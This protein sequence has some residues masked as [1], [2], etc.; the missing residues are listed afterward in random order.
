MAEPEQFSIFHTVKRYCRNC[1]HPLPYKAK[2]CANCGQKDSDGRIGMKSLMGRLWNNTFH[3]EGKFV[4]TAWQ[5]FIPGKVTLEF[6]KGKQDRYPHPIRLFAIVMFLFLFLLNQLWKN[7]DA[8][9]ESTYFSFQ[10][11]ED[12][13]RNKSAKVIDSLVTEVFDSTDVIDKANTIDSTVEEPSFSAYEKMKYNAVLY[14]IKYD[15]DSLPPGLKTPQA[16]RAVDSLMKS[17]AKRYALKNNGLQDSLLQEPLDSIG[18]GMGLWGGG[19]QVATLD[20]VRYDP[21]EIIKRYHVTSWFEKTM[22]RQGIK[23]YKT[24]E[25]FIHA[26]IG[27]LTWAILALV[28]LMS[29]VLALLYT[30]QHRYYVEHFIFLL[31]FHTGAMLLLLLALLGEM[32]GIWGTGIIGL[33]AMLPFPGMYL[34]MRR[35]YNQG[36]FKTFVKWLLYGFLYVF[37]FTF[38]FI[39]GMII[40]FAVF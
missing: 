8:G 32:L 19:V 17:F 34:G 14:D 15:Y 30:R 39:L 4:R 12:T 22:L 3:L 29:G 5:L 25:V 28:A 24:P 16:E 33:A 10:T 1:Y 2:Y 36:W 18:F 26:C 27:S 37:A 21:E 20:M 7:K 11:N 6:F 35:Y 38:L 31:H 9:N 13:D 40:V 23:S